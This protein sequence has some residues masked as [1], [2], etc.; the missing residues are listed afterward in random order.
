MTVVAHDK[1]LRDLAAEAFRAD[2]TLAAHGQ[3][4]AHIQEQQRTTF[5]NI[6]SLGDPIGSLGKRSITQP[7]DGI[8]A[9]RAS[10]AKDVSASVPVTALSA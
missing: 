5:S 9:Y 7:L 2:Q 1:R 10:E 8:S 3:E 4:L 6:D